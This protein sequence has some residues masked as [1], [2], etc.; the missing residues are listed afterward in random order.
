MLFVQNI[1]LLYLLD[2]SLAF[3]IFDNTFSTAQKLLYLAYEYEC[4]FVN[5]ND[6][7]AQGIDI[8][9]KNI[10]IGKMWVYFLYYV[11]T[12]HFSVFRR[13]FDKDIYP[14]GSVL[15]SYRA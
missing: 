15:T 14:F 1:N 2:I 13:F 7:G 3:V 10:K 11:E 5:V 12:E 8:L 4:G 6:L 9:N